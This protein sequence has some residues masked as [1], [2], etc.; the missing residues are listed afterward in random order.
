MSE[1]ITRRNPVLHQTT[2]RSHL[3]HYCQERQQISDDP[4]PKWKT[5]D[6]YSILLF[7]KC[8]NERFE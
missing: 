7:K 2:V 3:P 4:A 1:L 8:G 5:S 6:C